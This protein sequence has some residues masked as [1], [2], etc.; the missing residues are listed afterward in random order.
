MPQTK[1]VPDLVRGNGQQIH[2]ARVAVHPAFVIVEV[3]EDL[4]VVIRVGKGGVRQHIAGTIERVAIAMI[5]RCPADHN[6]RGPRISG[7]GKG[8]GC[9]CRPQVKRLADQIT[10]YISI[11]LSRPIDKCIGNIQLI[12]GGNG[13]IFRDGSTFIHLTWQ[14][15]IPIFWFCRGNGGRRGNRQGTS[16]HQA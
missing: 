11:Q 16:Q 5:S 12:P 9:L 14:L 6:I 13:S 15:I 1:R 4:A 10:L 3:Q 7:L 8:Q 2:V